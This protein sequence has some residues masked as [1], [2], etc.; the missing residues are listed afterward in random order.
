METIGHGA[1]LIPTVYVT[2]P[3]IVRQ[4]SQT[5]SPTRH[6]LHRQVN[7]R[8]LSTVR[9]LHPHIK[10]LHGALHIVDGKMGPRR[11]MSRLTSDCGPADDH[12][13]CRPS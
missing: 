8:T 5:M 11:I 4:N 1:H 7:S 6:P 3:K 9:Q 13:G 2:L 12:T 10:P